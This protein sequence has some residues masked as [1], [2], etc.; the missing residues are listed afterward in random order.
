MESDDN[1]VNFVDD[2][3]TTGIETSLAIDEF[4]PTLRSNINF[5][6]PESFKAMLCPAGL[7]ELRIA[8]FYQLQTLHSLSVSVRTNAHL[9]DYLNRYTKE[10]DLF[11]KKIALPNPVFD[12]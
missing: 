4:D 3:S 12:Y 6:D 7:E 11:S 2:G 1:P 10:T 9:L 5:G 8:L